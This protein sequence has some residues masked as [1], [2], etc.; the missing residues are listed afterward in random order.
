MASEI[1]GFDIW[2][3]LAKCFLEMIEFASDEQGLLIVGPGQTAQWLPVRPA[4]IKR[5]D[6]PTR[7]LT[8]QHR[9]EGNF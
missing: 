7:G 2:R 3:L 5:S 8:D 9:F 6:Q 1:I 4:C